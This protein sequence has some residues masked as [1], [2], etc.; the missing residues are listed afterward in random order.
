MSTSSS[1]KP[2][3]LIL[4]SLKARNN[5]RCFFFPAVLKWHEQDGALVNWTRFLHQASRLDLKL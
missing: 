5:P 1:L 2:A 4:D 3:L